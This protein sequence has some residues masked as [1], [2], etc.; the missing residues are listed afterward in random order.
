MFT[1]IKNDFIFCFVLFFVLFFRIVKFEFTVALHYGLWEKSPSR[2]PLRR[3]LLLPQA[4]ERQ[5]PEGST[6]LYTIYLIDRRS[7]LQ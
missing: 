7:A 3:F 5:L 1:L 6:Y 4:K 2:D